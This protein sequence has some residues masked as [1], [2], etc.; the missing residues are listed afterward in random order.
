MRIEDKYGPDSLLLDLPGIAHDH[1]PNVRYLSLIYSGYDLLRRRGGT[2][3]TGGSLDKIGHLH[4]LFFLV[5]DRGARITCMIQNRMGR[6]RA[7][8]PLW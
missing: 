7:A 8:F 3:V 4:N 6:Q 2:G 5:Y 1:L